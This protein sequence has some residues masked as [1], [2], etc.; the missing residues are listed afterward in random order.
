MRRIRWLL[1]TLM[2]VGASACGTSAGPNGKTIGPNVVQVTGTVRHYALEGGFWAIRGDDST[3]YDPLG[4][5]S[6]SFQQEGLRVRLK[7]N[8]RTDMASTH[9][10]G[11]IV[12]IVSIEAI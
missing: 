4:G 6:P 10:V 3:T 5:L 11:P 7:A 8:L 12:E 1:G 2:I 9:M